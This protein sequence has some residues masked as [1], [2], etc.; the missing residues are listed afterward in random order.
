MGV[1]TSPSSYPAPAV[2]I[3]PSAVSSA[4]VSPEPIREEYSPATLDVFP[5]YVPSPDTSLY[6]PA[7]SP[8]TP[9]QPLDTEFLSPGVR[10]LWITFSRVTFP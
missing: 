1:M 3:V 5:T 4:R 6:V 10:H 9:V 2:P 7:T 8:V